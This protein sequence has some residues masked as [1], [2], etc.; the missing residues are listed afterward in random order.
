VKI[1]VAVAGERETG[2]V[3]FRSL[4]RRWLILPMV[5]AFAGME[6]AAPGHFRPAGVD[7]LKKEL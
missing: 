4:G 2:P 3:P 5:C 7:K 6:K 1:A